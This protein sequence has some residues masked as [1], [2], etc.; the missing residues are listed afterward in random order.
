MKKYKSIDFHMHSKVSDGTDTPEEIIKKV[1]DVGIEFF[2]VS[3]HDAIEGCKTI[4]DIL[5]G[6]DPKFI[7]GAEFSCRDEYGKYHILGYMYDTEGE[8]INNLVNKGHTIRMNK[9]RYRLDALKSEYGFPFSD[10]DTEWI[11]SQ[12]NPGKPH[13]ANMM[14]KYGYVKDKVEAF[15]NYLNVIRVKSVHIGPEEAIQDILASGG[16]PVLAHPSYGDGDQIIVDDE[17]EERIKRLIGY[18]LKGVE[19]FYSGFS[20]KLQDEIL[21]Y[22]KKYNLLVSAGSD[23]HG[24]NKSVKLGD[25][26]LDSVEEYPEGLKRFLE[27][28]EG[29][30]NIS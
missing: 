4:K 12:P 14:I 28:A 29:Y 17:M 27:L 11:L 2:S 26:N 18:G 21:S 7:P 10:E 16:V 22:A 8:S 24:K 9:V 6:D 15:R 30:N 13:I 1:K 5:T 25:T 23:Y 19:A 20:P 3:D